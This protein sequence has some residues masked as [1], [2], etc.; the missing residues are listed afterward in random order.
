MA[1]FLILESSK[2]RLGVEQGCKKYSH[3]LS[4]LMLTVKQYNH[5]QKVIKNILL[6]EVSYHYPILSYGTT[7]SKWTNLKSNK[8]LDEYASGFG[9]QGIG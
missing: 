6:S 2:G 3:G 9:Q 7:K 1:C 5:R 8:Y 4:K